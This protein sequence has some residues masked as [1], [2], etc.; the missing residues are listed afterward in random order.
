MVLPFGVIE[1][2][3]DKGPVDHDELIFLARAIV[4]NSSAVM[5]GARAFSL[6]YNAFSFFARCSGGSSAK[7]AAVN[8]AAGAWL[9]GAAHAAHGKYQVSGSRLGL[10]ALLVPEGIPR[11]AWPCLRCQTAWPTVPA[12]ELS[13][14][15]RAPPLR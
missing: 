10:C 9:G 6:K 13:R 7:S 3:S 12:P 14:S 1:R 2:D 5:T 11:S 15:R 8:A 4:T